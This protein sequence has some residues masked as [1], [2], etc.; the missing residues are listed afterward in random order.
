MKF[1]TAIDLIAYVSMFI[2]SVKDS[3]LIVEKNFNLLLSPTVNL[4]QQKTA[5]TE[6]HRMFHTIK[7]R[8]FFMG[9]EQTGQYC[10]LLEKI[11]LALKENRFTL[12]TEQ[13]TT[14]T[15]SIQILTNDLKEIEQRQK[16]MDF[17]A[18]ITSLESFNI[19]VK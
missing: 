3:L 8:A 10:L 4:D 17:A 5:Y 15:Q 1:M 2:S 14:L 18:A 13:L 7:G 9:Y 11:F 19:Q 12:S 6:I 16:E